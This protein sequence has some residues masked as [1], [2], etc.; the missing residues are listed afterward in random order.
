[1]ITSN[2]N[3]QPPKN[4]SEAQFQQKISTPKG[5]IEFFALKIIQDQPFLNKLITKQTIQI[6]FSLAGSGKA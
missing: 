4:S 5:N 6:G 1:M 2:V 3:L